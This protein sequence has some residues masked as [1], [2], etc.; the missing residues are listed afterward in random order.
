MTLVKPDA[1]SAT[2]S[3]VDSAADDQAKY[4]MASE[5]APL[6]KDGLAVPNRPFVNVLVCFYFLSQLDSMTQF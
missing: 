2:D 4:F 6:P 1:A 3:S 5:D